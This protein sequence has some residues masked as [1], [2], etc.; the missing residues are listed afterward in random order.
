MIISC[1]KVI[2]DFMCQATIEASAYNIAHLLIQGKLPATIPGKPIVSSGAASNSYG[3][4][5]KD[6][7]IMGILPGVKN[8]TL[9]KFPFS[10]M[11]RTQPDAFKRIVD[12]LKI[13]KKTD[14]QNQ[15]ILDAVEKS[16]FTLIDIATVGGIMSG[17]SKYIEDH[18][19]EGNGENGNPVLCVASDSFR[20]KKG[21][22]SQSG[23][24]NE[25]VMKDETMYEITGSDIVLHSGVEKIIEYFGSDKFRDTPMEFEAREVSYSI[26]PHQIAA[27]VGIIKIPAYFNLS[28]KVS[29]AQLKNAA[30]DLNLNLMN[31]MLNEA[32]DSVIEEIN[33]VAQNNEW[34][35]YDNEPYLLTVMDKDDSELVDYD[36]GPKV[37]SLEESLAVMSR[38][39]GNMIIPGSPLFDETTLKD[40][41]EFYLIRLK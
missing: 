40:G 26:I 11:A 23:Y 22:R 9:E 16:E 39:Q 27:A 3:A 13:K 21:S 28:G 8:K 34:G 5:F 33:N 19:I 14:I 25:Y 30:R 29:K 4:K 18:F 20:I 15:D 6:Q 24:G 10:D 36:S 32:K 1:L 2:D 31:K 38:R 41:T 12:I 35:V 17:E 7:W 37:L